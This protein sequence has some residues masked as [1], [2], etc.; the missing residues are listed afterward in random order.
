MH[1]NRK[2]AIAH[3]ELEQG[4]VGVVRK[5]DIF[6][7]SDR[8]G[9]HFLPEV[10]EIKDCMIVKITI[11]YHSACEETAQMDSCLSDPSQYSLNWALIFLSLPVGKTTF[12]CLN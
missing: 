9:H 1:F 3:I 7:A 2:S 12:T 6:K 4:V 11:G 5:M 8:S 10:N